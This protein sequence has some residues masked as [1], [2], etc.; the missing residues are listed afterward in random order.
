MN[1]TPEQALQNV[2]AAVRRTQMT[3]DEHIAVQQSLEVLKKA[4]E[5]QAKVETKDLNTSEKA[6]E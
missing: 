4:I 2:T 1:I 5:P 6:P 3:L